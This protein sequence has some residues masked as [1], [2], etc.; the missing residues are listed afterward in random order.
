LFP[1][2]VEVP[3]GQD[4]PVPTRW[5]SD[6]EMKAWRSFLASHTRLVR[7]LDSELTAEQ[8]ISLGDH[9]VLIVLSESGGALRMADLADMITLSRSGLT[10]R[11]DH[12]VKD[13]LVARH[14]CPT[15]GRGILAVLTDAGRAQLAEAS[16]THV[17]GVRRHFVDR[18]DPDELAQLADAHDR[19]A[20]D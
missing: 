18:F 12:L 10:R 11:V 19:I 4:G 8:G 3:I 9:E 17:A 1:G 13:G 15:D 20:K 2:F 16:P 6:D 14:R 7:A 5:L